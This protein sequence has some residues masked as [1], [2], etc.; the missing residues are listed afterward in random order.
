[1]IA[2]TRFKNDTWAANE[3]YRKKNNKQCIYGVNIKMPDK[4]LNAAMFVVEM[5]NDTNK[6]EGIGLIR[7]RLVVDK[8]YKIYDNGDY[9]RYIYQG[10]Y[11]LSRDHIADKNPELVEIFD[12]ILFKGK[13]HL[14]RISGISAVSQKVFNNWNFSMEKIQQELNLLFAI[15]FK[16]D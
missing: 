11:W 15:E 14:K 13:S 12:K 7:S 4:Y 5:N 8:Y 2:S 1:M 16:R 6:I 3:D 9:N 10:N